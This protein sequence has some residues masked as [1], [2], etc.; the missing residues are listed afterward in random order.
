MLSSPLASRFAGLVLFGLRLA[1]CPNP[2]PQQ[3]AGGDTLADVS[4]GDVA[5]D[6]PV[7]LPPTECSSTADCD[8]KWAGVI[9]QCRA[10]FCDAGSCVLVDGFDGGLCEL[11]DPCVESAACQAGECVVATGVACDDDNACTTDACDPS[12]GCVHTFNQKPCDDATSCT[13]GDRCFMGECTGDLLSCDD[14]N[15]CTE[16]VCDPIAGCRNTNVDIACS[17]GDACTSGDLCVSGSCVPGAPLDCDDGEVCTTE[18]CDTDEGCVVT[19]LDGVCDDG[20]ACTTNTNCI[21]GACKG[22]NTVCDD[23]NAC[24]TDACQ[25]ASG[26]TFTN[27]TASCSDGDSCTLNDTCSAGGCVPGPID[28]LCCTDDAECD[29]G[30]PCTDDSCTNE[31]CLF[32]PKLC[33]DGFDCTADTCVGG[34]CQHE[35]L[36]PQLS[37]PVVTD[38]FESGSLDDWIIKTNNPEVTWQLDSTDS[39][40]GSSS[41]YCGNT[42]AYTYDFGMTSASLLRDVDLPVANNIALNFWTFIDFDETGTCSYDK[43]GLYIDGVLQ[44][45]EMCSDTLLWVQQSYNLASFAGQ[46]VSVELRFDTVDSIANTGKGIWIDDFEIVVDGAA[47]CCNTPAD[48]EPGAGSGCLAATCHPTGYTCMVLPA[49]LACDD[50]PAMPCEAP[51]CNGDG[52]CS[53]DDSACCADSS[54]CPDNPATPCETGLCLANGDCGYDDSLCCTAPTDCPEAAQGPCAIASCSPEGVCT[55]DASGCP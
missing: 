13:T 16:D 51:V 36:G 12:A 48:C 46:T 34:D 3:D 42:P 39:N 19:I 5:A 18:Y 29:D 40:G 33:D 22:T 53:L 4:P 47:D 6:A 27:N 38:D 30:D 37:G 15:A 8:A 49:E 9:P 50:N 55:Y 23:S 2:Q 45:P 26:C 7:E 21:A 32:A 24:T 17:D 1:A 35:A 20:D 41:L 28:P 14:N 43:M 54:A 44:L 11:S 31:Y 25:P 52:P 10:A